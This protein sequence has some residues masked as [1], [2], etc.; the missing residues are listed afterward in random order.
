MRVYGRTQDVLTGKKTWRTVTTDINGFNDSVYLTALAQVCKLNL[1]ESPF[2]GTYGIPAHASV[3]M[4]VFPDYYM[5]RI[6]QQYAPYFGSLILSP[7][8][9]SEDDDGRPLPAYNINVM[10]NYGALIGIQ[11]RPRYPMEQPI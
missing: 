2:F 5:T 8:P 4:Q 10:T 6:Q 11:T 1:G 7:I 3:V 9:D